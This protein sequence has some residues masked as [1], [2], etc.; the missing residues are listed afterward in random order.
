[1]KQYSEAAFLKYTVLAIFL[2]ALLIIS[3]LLESLKS[4]TCE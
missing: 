1:M 2:V 3:Q 4:S